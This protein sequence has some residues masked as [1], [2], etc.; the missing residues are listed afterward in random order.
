MATDKR[1]IKRIRD[2]L[3][4][5]EQGLAKRNKPNVSLPTSVVKAEGSLEMDKQIY[6]QY[7]DLDKEI[8]S[9]YKRID[10]TDN[11]DAKRGLELQ[12]QRLFSQQNT[13][14][15][16]SRIANLEKQIDTL[17]QQRKLQ[18]GSLEDD[19]LRGINQQMRV[20]RSEL[21]GLEKMYQ[22]QGIVFPT[23]ETLRTKWD[24]KAIGHVAQVIPRQH[25]TMEEELEPAVPQQAVHSTRTAQ[26]FTDE[27][28]AIMAEISDLNK[29]LRAIKRQFNK[30][31]D[32]GT[33]GGVA[34]M[35]AFLD[36]EKVIDDAIWEKKQEL[37]SIEQA[38][39]K[40]GLIVP[41]QEDF[42]DDVGLPEPN[43]DDPGRDSEFLSDEELD[44]YELEHG[45]AVEPPAQPSAGDDYDDDILTDEQ[46]DQYEREHGIGAEPA[47]LPTSTAAQIPQIAAKTSYELMEQSMNAL[48]SIKDTLTDNGQRYHHQP[49][50]EHLEETIKA[51]ASIHK[52]LKGPEIDEQLLNVLHNL[53]IKEIDNVNLF[54]NQQLKLDKAPPELVAINA[55]FDT[56]FDSIKHARAQD[57]AR[58]QQQPQE[59]PQIDEAARQEIQAQAKELRDACQKVIVDINLN[60]PSAN[61]ATK[62]KL[63][64]NPALDRNQ[65]KQDKADIVTELKD[66]TQ[67][68]EKSAMAQHDIQTYKDTVN[69]LTKKNQNLDTVASVNVPV[70][71]LLV[72]GKEIANSA[73]E[74]VSKLKDKMATKVKHK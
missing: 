69:N 71:N 10:S 33:L 12:V 62:G 2:Q 17:D 28:S 36:K 56:V 29:E 70:K 60:K 61:I 21:Q 11:E 13:L 4:R 20:L 40:L 46:L 55:Q 38:M 53:M 23:N 57:N 65:F 48:Q 5:L 22:S 34:G 58:L 59:S 64:M 27:K 14:Y 47:A 9:M 72:T 42:Q 1:G 39:T 43:M 73:M 35:Q 30:D 8:N 18:T 24:A 3:N 54:Y 63:I 45:M 6:Q 37:K 74:K 49:R 68:F 31:R 19:H 41:G 51:V 66:A 50:V 26:D 44:A 16:Q 67:T 32:K 25:H 52:S 7:Y 15:D